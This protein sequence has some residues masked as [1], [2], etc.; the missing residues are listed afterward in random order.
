MQYPCR[1]ILR[2]NP[3]QRPFLHLK[4]SLE[5]F[6][7][8]DLIQEDTCLCKEMLLRF[9]HY[10][11]FHYFQIYDRDEYVGL[12]LQEFSETQNVYRLEN[13]QSLP[14]PNPEVIAPSNYCKVDETL[15]M[16]CSKL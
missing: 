15:H 12:L 16:N 8:R 11:C 1:Q 13:H 10:Q 6:H 3:S 7:H 5:E 14:I 9:S 2:L 4:D